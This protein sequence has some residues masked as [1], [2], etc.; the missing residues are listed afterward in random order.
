MPP[1]NTDSDS[2]QAA[3]SLARACPEFLDALAGLYTQVDTA[4]A[5]LN[6]P[7]RAC[8]H[9]CRFDL[10]DHRLYAS[11]GELALLSTVA[12]PGPATVLRCPWQSQDRCTARARRTLGCRVFFCQND[13]AATGNSLYE[14]FHTAIG[15]LHHHYGV[16]YH[17]V[18][19]TAALAVLGPSRDRLGLSR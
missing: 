14:T 15:D 12:P 3:I 10:A 19:M 8:G 2:L 6:A 7:C 17:Y 13:F 1:T 18:E 11:T 9:C 16:E 5:A 4:I